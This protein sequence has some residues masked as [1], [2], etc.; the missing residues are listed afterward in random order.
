[1]HPNEYVSSVDFSACEKILNVFIIYIA[2]NALSATV[3]AF[4][5]IYREVIVDLLPKVAAFLCVE[6]N[7]FPLLFVRFKCLFLVYWFECRPPFS[8]LVFWG[9]PCLPIVEEEG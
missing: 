1:M 3:R 7:H 8:R 2:T 9:V 5:A 6:A 4:V